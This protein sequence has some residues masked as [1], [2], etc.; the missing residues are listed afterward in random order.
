VHPSGGFLRAV[1]TRS[2]EALIAVKAQVK[3]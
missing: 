2:A 3:A 1:G